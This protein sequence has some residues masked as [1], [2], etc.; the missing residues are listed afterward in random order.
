MIEIN[1]TIKKQQKKKSVVPN[2]M[3]H[4]CTTLVKIV[5]HNFIMRKYQTN[6]NWETFHKIKALIIQMT[7]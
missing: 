5:N 7:R 1:I 6:P 3:Y 4:F 2:I